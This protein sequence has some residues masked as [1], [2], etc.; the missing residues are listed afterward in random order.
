MIVKYYKIS[1]EFHRVKKNYLKK[2]NLI[3][4]SGNF[5]LG[6][7]NKKFEKKISQ[8][9]KVN[10]VC[11]VG[12]GSDA[13]EIGLIA[14][15]IKK[16]DEV[17]TAT[18]SWV[19]SLNSILN[20]GAKPIL[21]DV[22][23]DFNIDTEQIKKAITKK[24]KAIM[25][26]HLNGLPANMLEISKIAKKCKLKIIEDSA[27]AILSK[28][29]NNYAG[30]IGDVGCFSMHPTKNLGVAGDGG[31]IT[32]KN[33]NIFK[34]IKLISNHGMDKKGNSVM[35]GRNSRLDEIQ[36][37]FILHKINYLKKDTK[38]KRQIASK[39][40]QALNKLVKT[41]YTKSNSKLL[42]TYHRYVIMLK[43]KNER[44][45]LKKYLIKNNIET[46]I[47]YPKPIHKYKCFAK[48]SFKKNLENSEEQ[49]NK[50]LSLPCNHFMTNDEVD[51]VIKKIKQFLLKQN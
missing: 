51:F 3:F 15:G 13:L 16:G 34:K 41:P 32:T 23:N 48:Y 11:G 45:A 19:S 8:L 40:T 30:T 33:K 7:S 21:V 18:N 25:P 44:D 1:E 50:I 6:N 49:A 12:N 22:D 39:Y 43:H 42:H 24:T 26:V 38:R 17:I 10:Y 35:V 14:I 20:I 28:H 27:Q 2:I 36:A 46:K 31:F 37:E 5:I 47:H 9:L 29:H 4:N